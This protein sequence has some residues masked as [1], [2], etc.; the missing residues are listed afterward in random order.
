MKLTQLYYIFF[1]LTIFSCT[2]SDEI[3]DT[4]DGKWTLTKTE[5]NQGDIVLSSPWALIDID[6]RNFQLISTGEEEEEI[7]RG[8][9]EICDN[10][11]LLDCYVFNIDFK[12]IGINLPLESNNKKIIRYIDGELVFSSVCCEDLSYYFQK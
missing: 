3:V 9:I 10:S 11:Y 7:A 12:K 2:E 6:D 4:I 8:T 1:L 5:G